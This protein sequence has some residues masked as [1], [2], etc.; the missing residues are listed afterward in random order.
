M[1]PRHFLTTATLLAVAFFSTVPLPAAE[2][3]DLPTALRLAGAQNLDVQLA[4]EKATEARAEHRAS[5]MAFY[6][7]LAPGLVYK[8]HDGLAQN[9]DGRIQDADKDLL[10][11][12]PAL[13]AQVDLGEAIYRRLAARQLARAAEAAAEAQRQDAVMLAALAYFDLVQEQAAERIAADAVKAAH[14]F[15]QQLANA[16]EAGVALKG[17]AL[18]AAVQTDK[19]RLAQQQAAARRRLASMRLAAHLRLDPTVELAARDADLAPLNYF[20][21]KSTSLAAL[22]AQ[23]RSRPELAASQALTDAA[24]AR[25]DGA[26]Y[27]PLIPTVSGYASYGGLSGGPDGGPDRDGHSSDFGIALTWKIGPGGLFDRSRTE[28]AE[29]RLRQARLQ[30][31]KTADAI[32]TQVV[33]AHTRVRSL[34]EQSA[35]AAQSLATA[36]KALQIAEQRNEFGLA[37]VLDRLTAQQDLVAARLAHAA[38][39]AE[40]NRAQFALRRASGGRA[41]DK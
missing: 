18:R 33:E 23:A 14:D 22:I 35:T 36:Q 39:L 34:R 19:A 37:A 8:A 12:G 5:L 15:S 10:T 28:T 38:T 16:V 7:W 30:Q 31:A 25:R 9:T 24:L 40:A 20:P 21:A 27:G 26:K 2:P 1:I 3:I 32:A 17:D 4:R 41:Q 11:Y 29:S 13:T 6:P